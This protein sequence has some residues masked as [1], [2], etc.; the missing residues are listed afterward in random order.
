MEPKLQ[1]WI[2]MFSFFAVTVML[3]PVIARIAVQ[4]TDDLIIACIACFVA[5]LVVGAIVQYF[6]NKIDGDCSFLMSIVT[7]AIQCL[8]IYVLMDP[9]G[10]DLWAAVATQVGMF[11]ILGPIFFVILDLDW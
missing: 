7:F 11:L 9:L 2:V 10:I 5:A 4:L 8:A 6:W 1:K 3:S